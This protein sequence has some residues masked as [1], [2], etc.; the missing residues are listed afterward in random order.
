M[1]KFDRCRL[2]GEVLLDPPGVCQ[3]PF[4]ELENPSLARGFEKV[5]WPMAY[6][7]GNTVIKNK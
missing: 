1:S 4:M 2:K 3:A 5:N 7:Y 6:P